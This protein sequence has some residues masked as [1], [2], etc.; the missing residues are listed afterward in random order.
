MTTIFEVE[1]NVIAP[2]IERRKFTTDE[3]QK[4]TQLGILPEESGWEIINGE[5]IRRMSIGSNHAGTVKRISEIIRD[6][7]GKTAI[8][9][10]QDPIHLDKYNDPEPDIALL[11]RRS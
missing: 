4:M 3:Y 5:V 1:E 10:V 11:K 2:P 6:A 8:I 7:I 9:S